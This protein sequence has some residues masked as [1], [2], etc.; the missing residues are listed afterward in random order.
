MKEI[1]G[2]KLRS[3][4]YGSVGK[5]VL[6]VLLVLFFLIPLS[7][8]RVIVADRQ[9]RSEEAK[10]EIMALWGG[11]QTMAGPLIAVPYRRT[12]SVE[13]DRGEV[14]ETEIKNF[15][16]TAEHLD[17]RVALR[18]E[19]RKRGIYEVPVYAAEMILSG[20]FLKPDIE[21]LH[22]EDGDIYWKDAKLFIELPEMRALEAGTG[23]TWNGKSGDFQSNGGSLGL[24]PYNVEYNL[25]AGWENNEANK[26]YV[27]LNTRGAGSLEF[28]PFGHETKV[29]LDSDWP[30]P[31][32]EGA[33]L[34]E[35]RD[36]KDEEGFTASWSIHA[37]ARNIP[38]V[39]KEGDLEVW[40]ISGSAFGV[41]LYQPV[42]LYA[43]VERSVK[44]G[45]LFILLPF[46][47]F[48]LMEVFS[49]QR[50]HILQY[51]MIGGANT[52]F[53]LLLLSV[54]E[55][56]GFT[57]AYLLGAGGTTVLIVF[58]TLAIMPGR[59]TGLA[60]IPV[61]VSLYL[62]LYTVLQ[63]EDYALL[64]GSVGLFA[65]LALVMVLTR[66]I[67]WYKLNREPDPIKSTESGESA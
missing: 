4:S 36:L 28:I 1:K 2:T 12:Y 21:K 31:S 17:I 52:L 38:A 66:N 33:F 18:T 26:F 15:F 57:S 30:A 14:T 5:V 23:I 65:L 8:I 10:Q 16:I 50:I 56:L 3:L 61:M 59:K 67:D 49:R 53:Y 6:I 7:M 22:L 19:V 20:N 37:L 44:Y 46:L 11:P 63:S 27:T 39:W 64:I 51:L 24:F 40:N 54:S 35:E 48:F 60:M 43:R 62:F 58:Y 13:T 34:P 32:F 9:Y 47:A 25:E 29:F 42:D 41:S 45:V 55:H